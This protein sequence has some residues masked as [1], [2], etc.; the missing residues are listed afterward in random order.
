MFYAYGH[1]DVALSDWQSFRTDFPPR[2]IREVIDRSEIQLPDWFVPLARGV[3]IASDPLL[4]R[5]GY[6]P[7]AKRPPGWRKKYCDLATKT[8][9]PGE[10]GLPATLAARQYANQLWWTVERFRAGQFFAGTMRRRCTS[11][12]IAT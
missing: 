8:G 7:G 10:D 12:S 1:P 6:Y 4:H 3:A 9:V 11:L 2:L 5:A